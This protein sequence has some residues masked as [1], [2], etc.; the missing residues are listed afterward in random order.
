[1]NQS[2]KDESKVRRRLLPSGWPILL[3]F[4]MG[5]LLLAAGL[6]M[7]RPPP[8]LAEVSSGKRPDLPPSS[9]TAPES[10]SQE[11]PAL[12]SGHLYLSDLRTQYQNGQM[13]LTIPSLGV[14]KAPVQNGTEDENL[15]AG[16]GLFQY[17]QMPSENGGNVSIA[18]HRDIDGSIFYYVHNL[19]AGDYFYLEWD[20]K[21]YR[22]LYERTYVVT[23][24]NWG[25]IEAQGYSCLTLVSCDPIGTTLNRIVVQSELSERTPYTERYEFIPGYQP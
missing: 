19:S 3:L 11:G 13:T 16:P 15:S 24:D 25:P 20:N 17:A 12:E 14:E 4:C 1:M 21:I 22:Y 9:A 8:T 7:M 6:W 10:G 2:E 18:G 5:F 23:P